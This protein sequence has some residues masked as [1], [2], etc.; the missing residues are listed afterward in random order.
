MTNAKRQMQAFMIMVMGAMAGAIDNLFS[1]VPKSGKPER[2]YYAPLNYK[3]KHDGKLRNKPCQC[4]SGKKFKQ[5][6]WDVL[7]E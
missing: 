5:C 4:G 6:C 3:F 1:K 2:N 7:G